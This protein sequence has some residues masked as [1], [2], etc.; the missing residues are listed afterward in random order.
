MGRLFANVSVSAYLEQ[1]EQK[2]REKYRLTTDDVIKS[3]SQAL[4]F[5]PRKLYD[6][7]GRLK[8]ITELDEDTIAALAGLEITEVIGGGEN[9]KPAICTKKVKWLDKNT[10][11]EQAM[12]HLGMFAKDKD[13][14]QPPQKLD[15]NVKLSPSEAYLRM[16]RRDGK[17]KK[18]A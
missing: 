7:N 4:H 12:K 6:E 10:V 3:L 9:G 8:K 13:P 5:D 14:I 17:P 16:L 15:V 2:I 11:R 18:K 1:R